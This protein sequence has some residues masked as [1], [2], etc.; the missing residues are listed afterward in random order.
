[1]VFE[2]FPLENPKTPPK[3]EK[4]NTLGGF[5]FCFFWVGISAANPELISR[6]RLLLRGRSKFWPRTRQKLNSSR[7]VESRSTSHTSRQ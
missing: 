4:K 5:V 7:L 3:N 6:C 1:M 2:I